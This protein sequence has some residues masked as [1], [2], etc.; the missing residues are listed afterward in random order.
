MLQLLR[1][2]E[3]VSWYENDSMQETAKL[4]FWEFYTTDKR[5][6]ELNQ[7]L[8]TMSRTKNYPSKIGEDE[9]Y[10]LN[11]VIFKLSLCMGMC[12]AMTK[13]KAQWILCE[14]IYTKREMFKSLNN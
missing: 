10:T 6:Y 1:L 12:I 9:E 5:K 3:H 2:K 4:R 7:K 13:V 14:N 8:K 11:C